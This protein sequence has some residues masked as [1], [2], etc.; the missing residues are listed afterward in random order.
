MSDAGVEYV[1]A[2]FLDAGAACAAPQGASEALA[3]AEAV[4]RLAQ[5]AR[6]TG[7]PGNARAAVDA[8]SVALY[9]ATGCRSRDLLVG[10]SKVGTVSLTVKEGAAVT[11][12]E[13]FGAWAYANGNGAEV[14]T[15]NLAW[16][17]PS[18]TERVVALVRR[19]NPAA[20]AV[21]HE[22]DKDLEKHLR[23]G[24]GGACVADGGEVVP[25]VEWRRSASTRV[26]G[27]KPERVADALRASGRDA[28][29][30][31]LLGGADE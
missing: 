20:V 19:M 25:G 31:M 8:E 18:Q 10:G 17:T 23:Q 5:K 15:V 11:D 1:E 26:S 6:A 9:E 2:E 12:A 28:G 13:A 7:E 30:L 22:A 14:E 16:L 3:V 4:Y 21:R 24:P 27:C 29:L